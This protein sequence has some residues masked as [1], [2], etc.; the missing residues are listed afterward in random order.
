MEQARS[1]VQRLAATGV[2]PVRVASALV[3][4]VS[5]A[6]GL[7]PAAHLRSS[8][9]DPHPAIAALGFPD[10]SPR[11]G[12]AL[13][14]DLYESALTDAAR[15]GGSHYTPADVAAG[16]VALAVPAVP[17][18]TAR[19]WDPACGGGS[20]LL[21][22]ADAALAAGGDAGTVVAEQLW[23]TDT[24][25]GAV[26]VAEAA[27]WLWAMGHGVDVG[28]GAH[29]A[30]ADA[31]GAPADGGWQPRPDQVRGE[32]GRG[33]RRRDD[34]RGDDGGRD[35]G[36]R[37]DRARSRA[38]DASGPMDRATRQGFDLVVAN[39]PF[40]AQLAGPTVRSGASTE[41]LR[42][43]WGSDVVQPYTDTAALFLVA[44]VEALAPGGALAMILP[45]SV[46]SARDA[47]GVR[48]AAAASAE[49]RGL[50]MA[51]EPVF[52]A[53]VD[54]CAVVLHRPADD[55]LVTSA[56]PAAPSGS[57]DGQPSGSAP[58]PDATADRGSADLRGETP[59]PAG[60]QAPGRRR[61]GSAGTD[62]ERWRGRRFTVLA[63]A[64]SSSIAAV[65]GATGQAPNWAPLALAA[66]G[67]P[68]PAV[69]SFGRLG[70]MVTA[71][72]GFRDEYY[73]L[74]GHVGEAPGELALDGADAPGS[75]GDG[76]GSDG[77]GVG[78]AA[79]VTAGLIDPGRCAWGERPAR[80][81]GARYL[82]PVVDL[83]SLAAAG[84][85]A[86]V[87]AHDLLVPKVVVATQTRVGEAAVDDG[88]R[89]VASTP[90]VAVVADPDRLWQVAAVICSPVGSV[91]ALVAAAGS[92]RSVGAIRQ[93]SASVASLP[94]PVDAD[95]WAEGADAL[96]CRDRPAFLAAM[97]AAYE[98]RHPSEVDQWWSDRSPWTG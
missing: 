29:L 61:T 26:V 84:G 96:R 23:G 97:A 75:E 44:G 19:S 14:G 24:D 31:L 85:R 79:L 35:D 71:R 58:R 8:S 33:D 82:R 70:S 15:D 51:T 5:G 36:G 13:L 28:P 40:Q 59:T 66:L 89:W 43:R 32:R 87:W 56:A 2:D 49:L 34:G 60:R 67:V 54:V 1:E 20:L 53:E 74:V 25:R 76:K 98:L 7:E 65:T 30:V 45:T 95:A 68:D 78:L 3:A 12:A 88:G 93:S 92:G 63:P 64:T 4:A 83:A 55:Q 9:I 47:A 22:V 94:L 11:H 42:R 86:S 62:V 48:A 69:R 91:A 46:L 10:M 73:G 17:A 27:L 52:G 41:A 80:F 81:A 21:A 57:A 39:P 6:C 16:V 77:F 72:S 37:D 50:W 90:T 18:A 38:G